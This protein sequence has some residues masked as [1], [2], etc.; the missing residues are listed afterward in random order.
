M[1]AKQVAALH[2]LMGLAKPPRSMYMEEDEPSPELHVTVEV[3]QGADDGNTY[4]A[5]LWVVEGLYR[6]PDVFYLR[7]DG[8]V[9]VYDSDADA[10][11]QIVLLRWQ[12][13]ADSHHW[14]LET[15][16]EPV[17]DPSPQEVARI[18]HD[19]QTG[20]DPRD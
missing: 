8:V 10:S 19:A 3:A 1:N 15:I 9:Y 6:F 20:L 13:D 12:Y 4:S 2:H 18:V 7:G 17:A 14:T 5:S 16:S 11:R